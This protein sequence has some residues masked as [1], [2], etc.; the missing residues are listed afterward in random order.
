MK[1]IDSFLLNS[2]NY[3]VFSIILTNNKLFYGM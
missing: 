1:L 2:L 3:N